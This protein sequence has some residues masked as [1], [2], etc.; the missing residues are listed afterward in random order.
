MNLKKN[1]IPFLFGIIFF[2]LS[3]IAGCSGEGGGGGSQGDAEQMTTLSINMSAIFKSSEEGVGSM[4]ANS[5]FAMFTASDVYTGELQVT[6]TATMVRETYVWSIYVDDDTFDVQSNRQ[7]VLTPGNYEF[8]LLV[9]KGNQQYAGSVVTD[10]MDGSNSVPL[11]LSPIIGDTLMDVSLLSTLLDFKFSYNPTELSG[12]VAPQMGIILDSTGDEQIFA[13]NPATGISDQYINLPQ[14]NYPIQLKLYDGSLQI[15]KSKDN[16]GGVDVIV[17]QQIV[18]NIIPLYGEMLITLSEEGG[19]ASFYFTIPSEVVDEVGGLSDLDVIFKSVGPGNPLQETALNVEASGDTF[20]ADVILNDFQHGAIDFS[21]EFFDHT[22]SE[23]VATCNVSSAIHSNVRNLVCGVD[24]HKRSIITGNLLGV[25]GVFVEDDTYFHVAGASI[26][27]NGN[28]LGITDSNGNLTLFLQAGS[29]TLRAENTTHYGEKLLTVS[30]LETDNVRITL[31]QLISGT[32]EEFTLI[33]EVLD[34][35]VA[36]GELTL[37][38]YAS[39]AVIDG[40]IATDANGQFTLLADLTGINPA[41]VLA[42]EV[43]GRQADP[44]NLVPNCSGVTPDTYVDIDKNG[45][46]DTTTDACLG[47]KAEFISIL[48]TKANVADLDLDANGIIDTANLPKLIVTH[49]TTAE[50]LILDTYMIDPSNDAEVSAYHS[51]MDTA[52]A[53][54]EQLQQQVATI[55]ALLRA[56][57]HQMTLPTNLMSGLLA[58]G[59]NGLIERM[60]AGTFIPDAADLAFL[61]SVIAADDSGALVDVMSVAADL[62][63]VDFTDTSPTLD[64]TDPTEVA[65][66]NA[67]FA[68]LLDNFV[69]NLLSDPSTDMATLE[70][71]F[72]EDLHPTFIQNGETRNQFVAGFIDMVQNGLEHG[73]GFIVNASH[74]GAHLIRHVNETGVLFYDDVNEVFTNVDTGYK[75]YRKSG[76]FFAEF[77]TSSFSFKIEDTERGLD[78]FV[79]YDG[80]EMK[81]I[82]D[83]DKFNIRFGARNEEGERE[84]ELFIDDDNRG[85]PETRF[86]IISVRVDVLDDTLYSLTPAELAGPNGE[87]YRINCDLAEAQ[88]Q[89]DATSDYQCLNLFLLFYNQY[90]DDQYWGTARGIR[91][92][93]VSHQFKIPDAW[94][95]DHDTVFTITVE[96]EDTFNGDAPGTEV[97]NKSFRLFPTDEYLA[98][99]LWENDPYS[100]VDGNHPVG[101]NTGLTLY[102]RFRKFADSAEYVFPSDAWIRVDLWDPLRDEDVDWFERE[103]AANQRSITING[104]LSAYNF[105]ELSIDLTL[106]DGSQAEAEY[107]LVKKSDDNW[108]AYPF[109][110]VQLNERYHTQDNKVA[111]IINI[112]EHSGIQMRSSFGKIAETI[113]LTLYDYSPMWSAPAP[114]S[115]IFD[116]WFNWYAADA[117]GDWLQFEETGPSPRV[118]VSYD[119]YYL[120]G[121]DISS[122]EF[123][124]LFDANANHQ[125]QNINVSF[126][127][128]YIT[129]TW[130]EPVDTSYLQTK[131]RPRYFVGLHHNWNWIEHKDFMLADPRNYQSP[132]ISVTDPSTDTI[133]IYIN[134]VHYDWLVRGEYNL[135][136][137]ISQITTGDCHQ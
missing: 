51:S 116:E 34:A 130:D 66:L 105:L 35:P 94:S 43:K 58:Y 53:F 127:G 49:V 109:G 24:L 13:L 126:D 60:I 1:E 48:G 61:E 85:D 135:I 89:I 59:T 2:A 119:P 129:A 75:V 128:T 113:D 86:H 6:N 56:I 9:S 124:K 95:P 104:D 121:S 8:S 97:V 4:G 50:T 131:D 44:L 32:T 40:P 102:W 20:I 3:L 68:T 16:P 69:A 74:S 42:L 55:G 47:L 117:S 106:P 96:Y 7:L 26:S 91:H 17:G 72:I 54:E 112:F 10:I 41:A 92:D 31:D 5:F 103:M 136:C 123:S 93:H 108:Y 30:A 12:I 100:L 15:G 37:I 52:L 80:V 36:F 84:I 67:L 63:G 137:T 18:I 87:T 122:F 71:N 83:R 23:M 77:T 65:T 28:L 132:P 14:G 115:F 64:A 107:N 101:D 33:G 90:D 78:G 25:I 22:D 118:E 29:Y 133:Q 73:G 11:T 134:A 39:K 57:N 98:K 46:F 125:V 19:Q 88:A 45:S 70:A 120:P 81:E 21:L 38:D 110:M 79:I 114:Y 99:L 76:T 82:G 27:E 62:S 111:G